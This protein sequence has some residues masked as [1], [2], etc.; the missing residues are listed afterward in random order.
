MIT[1]STEIR[2]KGGKACLGT[3]TLHSSYELL[4]RVEF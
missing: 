4:K 1:F 2:Q 3:G